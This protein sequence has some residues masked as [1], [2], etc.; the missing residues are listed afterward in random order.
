MEFN[1]SY[2]LNMHVCTLIAI[3]EI[4]A[5]SSNATNFTYKLETSSGTV[6]VIIIYMHVFHAPWMSVMAQVD[7]NTIRK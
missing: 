5:N 1:D 6:T 3:H 7:D 4:K 2:K